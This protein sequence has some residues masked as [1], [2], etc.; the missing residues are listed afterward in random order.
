MGVNELFPFLLLLHIKL[1]F[2]LNILDDTDSRQLVLAL[3]SERKT[4]LADIL[5]SLLV[6]L[7]NMYKKT[8]I[9]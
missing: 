9:S 7:H 6:L 5:I 8:N 2:T 4:V 1:F 3:R